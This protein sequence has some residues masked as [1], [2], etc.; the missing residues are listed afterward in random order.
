MLPLS[1]CGLR[2]DDEAIRI[3]DVRNVFYV[4]YYFYK[5]RVLTFLVS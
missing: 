5:K 2:L 1:D 4:F 3:I